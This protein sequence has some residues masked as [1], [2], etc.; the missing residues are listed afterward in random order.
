M[1]SGRV[2]QLFKNR[3]VQFVEESFKYGLFK[4]NELVG[5]ASFSKNR[6]SNKGDFE[7]IRF[8]N[9]LHTT[10]IGGF[11][12]LLKYFVINNII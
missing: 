5:V 12:K 2:F 11:S 10:I 3:Y 7:L 9:K 8:A 4:N 1:Q 6:F